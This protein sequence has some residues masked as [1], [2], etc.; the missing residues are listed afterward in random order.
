MRIRVSTDAVFAL[1]ASYIL[2]LIC[3]IG[4]VVYYAMVRQLAG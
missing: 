4:L 2:T 1:A 3:Y